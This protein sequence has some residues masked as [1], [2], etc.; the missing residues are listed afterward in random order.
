MK[1]FPKGSIKLS[2]VEFMRKKK[3]KQLNKKVEDVKVVI[4]RD[5]QF[6]REEMEYEQILMSDQD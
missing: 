3:K 2:G 6:E 4:V 1:F 5:E